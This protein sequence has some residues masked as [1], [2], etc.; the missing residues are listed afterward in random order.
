MDCKATFQSQFVSVTCQGG[1][2]TFCFLSLPARTCRRYTLVPMFRPRFSFQFHLVLGLIAFKTTYNITKMQKK[3][4]HMQ[5]EF[6][7]YNSGCNQQN[8]DPKSIE[9][10]VFCKKFDLDCQIVRKISVRGHSLFFNNCSW[11]WK[12]WQKTH[13]MTDSTNLGCSWLDMVG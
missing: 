13:K 12:M 6:C 4:L 7:P 8:W 2:R 1:H 3:L 9:I 5:F 10:I 11:G